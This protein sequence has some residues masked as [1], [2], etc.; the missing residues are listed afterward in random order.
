MQSSQA[1]TGDSKDQTRLRSVPDGVVKPVTPAMRWM[2]LVA[3]FFVFNAGVQLFIW[4]EHT[5][6][7]FAWTIKSP[8]M[9][10]FLGAS[11]WAS[12]VLEFLVSRE[13]VWAN[14]RVAVPAILLFTTL[15]LVVT[16]IHIDRF[17]FNSPNWETL[18][19]TWLWLAVYAAVPLALGIILGHQLRVPGSDPQVDAPIAGWLRVMLGT[20]AAV[21]LILGAL[22]LLVPEA[23]IGVWPWALTPLTGRALGAWLI[24]WGAV[25][26]QATRENNYL[27][28]KH[29]MLSFV[30][31]ALLQ[32]IALA[33]FPSQVRWDD[34][35]LWLYLLFLASILAAGTYG[36]LKARRV[37]LT[38][39]YR[40]G[41][42]HV[43]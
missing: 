34:T 38:G 36:W 30:T 10:A 33:R 43:A 29:A 13:K 18:L 28:N 14:A 24:G 41:Q 40:A 1:I 15:T 23:L 8:L 22:Y 25:A 4:T 32:L 9:A 12:G 6:L 42:A 31:L 3:A 21:M 35:R 16:V 20:Q 7:Y 19:V 17:H 26:F 5:D 2:L 39:A 11:Y 37:R 27:R